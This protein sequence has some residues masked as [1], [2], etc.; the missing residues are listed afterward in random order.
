MRDEII[1]DPMQVSTVLNNPSNVSLID[2]VIR[3][4]LDLPSVVIKN[5]FIESLKP[6]NKFSIIFGIGLQEQVNKTYF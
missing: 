4:L 6:I 1:S 5:K 2:Q 3:Y